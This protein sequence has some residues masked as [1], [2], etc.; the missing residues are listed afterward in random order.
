M[1]TMA[2]QETEVSDTSKAESKAKQIW[3]KIG[4]N[5]KLD[6][7]IDAQY[8]YDKS[9]DSEKS[10]FQIRRARL[11]LKGSLSKW[12]DFRLQADFA[13]NPRLIDAFVKVNFCKYVKL[14][15]G[16]FKI[17]FSLEN[18][19]SPLDLETADNAQVISALSGYK[20]VTGISSYANGREIGLMLTGT[21]ASAEVKGEKIPILQY[22]IGVFGGNGINVKSDNMAKDISG[23]VMFTPFVKG[24]TLS[25]SGYYGRYDM[26]SEGAS[27]GVDGNRHRLA[28]GAQYDNNNLMVRSEYLWGTTDFAK[29]DETH[30]VFLLSAMRTQGAYLTIGYWFHFGWGKNCPVQQKLRPV[31]RVD[32]YEKDLTADKASLYYT[33]GVDWWPEKHVR[34][35]VNYTLRQQQAVKE[36]SHLFTTMVTVKF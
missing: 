31:L 3:E 35:Q 15:V 34:M 20:D 27:T 28:A 7:W 4:E 24:L 21:L 9:G 19:L 33:A 6:G 32:Y 10:A 25:V 11:D 13:P 29:Y 5:V 36:L 22:G 8:Q 12:V 23:R 17:P 14:Q 18:I 2:A 16:Q 1:P 30:D 26:L